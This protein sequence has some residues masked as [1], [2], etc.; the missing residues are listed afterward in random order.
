MLCSSSEQKPEAVNGT[1]AV[2]V[3]NL[4]AVVDREADDGTGAGTRGGEKRRLWA[5]ETQCLS[6][7]LGCWMKRRGEIVRL[8]FQIW[9]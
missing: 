3:E 9:P 1:T 8:F 7:V 2:V 4:E 5:R 6:L